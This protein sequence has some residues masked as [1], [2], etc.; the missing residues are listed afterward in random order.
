[1]NSKGALAKFGYNLYQIQ[2]DAFLTSQWAQGLWPQLWEI[3]QPGTPG[4]PI[5]PD[6]NEASKLASSIFEAMISLAEPMQYREMWRAAK[7][8]YEFSTLLENG[9]P[10]QR[11]TLSV[12]DVEPFTR[13][14]D[15][16]VRQQAILAMGVVV[17]QGSVQNIEPALKAS[18]KTGQQA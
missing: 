3:S 11:A 14:T 13:H 4:W 1:M 12:E 7:T 15:G 18:G 16:H 6:E 17:E 10:E 8:A 9:S 2:L 5:D